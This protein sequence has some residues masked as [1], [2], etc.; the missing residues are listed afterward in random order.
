MQLLRAL[1]NELLM[2]RLGRTA[3]RSTGST[4]NARWTGGGASD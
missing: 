1:R 3:G 4:K 2:I